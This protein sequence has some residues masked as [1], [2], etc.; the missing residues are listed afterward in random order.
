MVIFWKTGRYKSHVK[1]SKSLSTDD[2]Q[3][4]YLFDPLCI[5]V[6]VALFIPEYSQNPRKLSSLFGITISQLR[7][8]LKKIQ[9]IGFIELNENETI[10]KISGHQIHYG[11]DHPLMR[12]HQSLLRQKSGVQL[13]ELNENERHCFMGTFSAD[14]Q[15]YEKIK[16]KFRTFFRDIEP[17]IIKAPSLNVFQLNFEMFKWI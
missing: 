3:M 15:T 11:P 17:L 14:P 8:I 7:V 5:L 4:S 12:L 13:Q 9:D 1:V 2:E 6:H 16:T 10:A